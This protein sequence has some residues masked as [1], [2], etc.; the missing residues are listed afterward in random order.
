MTSTSYTFGGKIGSFLEAVFTIIIVVSV[1]F[2]S[3]LPWKK[4][5]ENTLSLKIKN[6]SYDFNR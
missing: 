4:I 6:H 5:I 2:Q 3:N 1:I